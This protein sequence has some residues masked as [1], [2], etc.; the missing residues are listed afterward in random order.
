MARLLVALLAGAAW[1][2]TLPVA[3]D[4]LA[5]GQPSWAGPAF[6]AVALLTAGLWWVHLRERR[7]RIGFAGGLA[8]W[9]LIGS[10]S[11][12]GVSG[13]LWMLVAMALLASAIAYGV[14]LLVTQSG[15]P[16]PRLELVTGLILFAGAGASVMFS[17][18]TGLSQVEAW[19]VPAHVVLAIG[20][21][22][23]TIA[24]AIP[25]AQPP[26]A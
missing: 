21:G 19:W 17:V 16:S 13:Y 26:P 22:A 2:V 7:P 20:I 6:V 5:R 25:T 9:L 23:A 24:S 4:A 15:A 12:L 14:V 1:V 11:L 18:T 8:G 10:V 3:A